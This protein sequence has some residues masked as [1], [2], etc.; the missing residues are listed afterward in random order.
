MHFGIMLTLLSISILTLV[1]EVQPVGSKS[2]PFYTPH[3]PIT[4]LSD[5]D[6]TPTNG[7]LS[8]SG[9]AK[10]PYVISGWNITGGEVGIRI[11]G[12]TKHFLIRNN[13]VANA[14]FLGI[15]VNWVAEGTCEVSHNIVRFI[16]GS[17]IP[18]SNT[19]RAL[20][21]HNDVQFCK[22]SGICLGGCSFCE[23]SHN[24]ARHN[25]WQPHG[26]HAGIYVDWSC[27]NTITDNYVD[28]NAPWVGLGIFII[29]W[30]HYNLVS[31]NVVSNNNVGIQIDTYSVGNTIDR[32]I[33]IRNVHNG[34]GIVLK[35]ESNIVQKNVVFSNGWAGVEVHN[36]SES[37]IF[38]NRIAG[39]LDG[40]RILWSHDNIVR[41]NKAENNTR[42]GI[43]V[44]MWSDRNVVEK[45][46]A[47][48]NG[49]F[50]LY[51]D[52]TGVDN[53]WE[54]NIYKTKSW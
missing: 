45:N 28:S 20:I 31:R 41:K 1:L 10:D 9:T 48:R 4:I 17:G 40:I 51:W 3:D 11:A 22:A 19:A 50:D 36:S 35:S 49:E 38:G 42:Y 2:E 53:V 16:E 33:V 14:S 8:G 54:K 30:S 23:V 32:N 26:L 43:A 24:I 37:L 52:I 21:H 5:S 47:V 34:I 7:V 6:F 12:T 39:N 29:R 13:W 46:K 15:N 18:V 27:N 44:M 25:N